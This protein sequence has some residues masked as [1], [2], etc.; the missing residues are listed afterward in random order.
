MDSHEED[1]ARVT[2]WLEAT[3][4]KLGIELPGGV[5]ALTLRPAPYGQPSY[6]TW[7]GTWADAPEFVALWMRRGAHWVNV[8]LHIPEDGTP[9]LLYESQWRVGDWD[10]PADPEYSVKH[11]SL[12]LCGPSMDR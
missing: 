11:V 7:E 8:V 10:G 4:A 2:E 6:G 12:N 3:I 9:Y 5:T 1:I